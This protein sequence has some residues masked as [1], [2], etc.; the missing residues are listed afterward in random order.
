M[1]KLYVCPYCGFCYEG[2]KCPYITCPGYRPEIKSV[3]SGQENKEEDNF[4]SSVGE[5]DFNSV[6]RPTD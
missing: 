4:Q 1:G 6:E 2:D 3:Q 5:Q